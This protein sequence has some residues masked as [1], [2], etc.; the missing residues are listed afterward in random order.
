MHEEIARILRMLEEGKI[1]A[2]EAERLIR[3]LR[4]PEPPRP[5]SH[6]RPTPEPDPFATFAARM[7]EI[8]HACRTAQRRQRRAAHRYAIWCRY[9]IRRRHEQERRRRAEHW[10]PYRRVKHVL[11][12]VAV[13]GDHVKPESRLNDLL[14]DQLAWDNLRFGLEEEFHLEIPAADLAGLATVQ[15]VADYIEARL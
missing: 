14:D 8:V 12:F 15:A 5:E 9:G 3:V 11:L 7:R 10:T 1:S 6:P 13:V 2:E 4:E